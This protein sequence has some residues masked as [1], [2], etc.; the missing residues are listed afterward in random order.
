MATAL[1]KWCA[2]SSFKTEE[3][4]RAGVEHEFGSMAFFMKPAGR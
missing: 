3:Q 4:Q 1:K 2:A